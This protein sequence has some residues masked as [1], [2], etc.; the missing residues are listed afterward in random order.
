MGV[1]STP[2]PLP[3][4][5]PCFTPLSSVLLLAALVPLAASLLGSLLLLAGKGTGSGKGASSQEEHYVG[6]L[7]SSFA[8]ID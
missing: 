5:R 4:A 2:S 6:I 3:V 7:L 1:E 8:Y